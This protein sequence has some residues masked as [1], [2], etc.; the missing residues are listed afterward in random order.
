[1][2]SDLVTA[3]VELR[4]EE[5]LELVQERLR[6]GEDPLEILG[7]TREALTIIGDRFEKKDYFIP[8][9]VFAGEIAGQVA[10]IL[11]PELTTEGEAESLGTVVIGT[12]AGDVH[13]I[14]KNIVS[15]MLETSGFA[16]HD[17]GVDVSPA[18]FVDCI[19]EIGPDVVGMSGFLTFSFDAM[20]ETV[21]AIAEAGLRDQVK[22]MIGGGVIDEQVV[23]Y[24]N[25]DA[26]GPD[27]MA[28]VSLAKQWVDA[29]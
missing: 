19:R 2:A 27:A 9:L 5:V 15:F 13:D 12:V 25:A 14:G 22:V 16:V 21:E 11:E 26:Y 20:K 17:L 24:T 3:M 18:T 1:M 29:K 23:K 10:E 7:E 8:D 6:A 4:E 28:A